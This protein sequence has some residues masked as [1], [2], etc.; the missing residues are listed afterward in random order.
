MRYLDLAVGDDA[1]G[2]VEP[3]QDGDRVTIFFTSRLWGYNG[4]AG[5][6]KRGGAAA[7]GSEQALKRDSVVLHQCM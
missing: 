4:M 6:A 2:N 5:G 7:R 3:V 1:V